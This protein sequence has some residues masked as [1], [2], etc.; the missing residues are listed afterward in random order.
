MSEFW[1]LLVAA[2]LSPGLAALGSRLIDRGK[3]IAAYRELKK[4]P[5]YD[6]GSRFHYIRRGGTVLIHE[7]Y[8]HS[9]SV[10]R[11]E[12]RGLGDEKGKAMSFRCREFIDLD[13][14]AEVSDA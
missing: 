4:D 11:V 8:V 10:G 2:V 1:A 5:L 7:C 3:A 13:P 6:V 9:L 12:V 14:V